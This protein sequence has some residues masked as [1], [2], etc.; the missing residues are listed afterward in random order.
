MHVKNVSWNEKGHQARTGN[1]NVVRAKYLAT[2]PLGSILK[3]NATSTK[4]KKYCISS[5]GSEDTMDSD[6]EDSVAYESDIQ[7]EGSFGDQCELEGIR[8]EKEKATVE[9]DWMNRIGIQVGSMVDGSS[10]MD[11]ISMHLLPVHRGSVGGPKPGVPLHHIQERT[12]LQERDSFATKGKENNVHRTNP[13]LFSSTAYDLNDVIVT[14]VQEDAMDDYGNPALFHADFGEHDH[15]DHVETVDLDTFCALEKVFNK[16]QWRHEHPVGN[17][18]GSFTDKR[19][20]KKNDSDFPEVIVGLNGAVTI[21]KQMSALTAVDGSSV[22]EESIKRS[23]ETSIGRGQPMSSTLLSSTTEPTDDKDLES[24]EKD[25]SKKWKNRVW[26]LSK[27]HLNRCLPTKL[28]D[29][30]SIESSLHR[31]EDN[32]KNTPSD[33]KKSSIPKKHSFLSKMWQRNRKDAETTL[34]S[35]STTTATA[36]S[37]SSS[38][39]SMESGKPISNIENKTSSQSE[40]SR[41]SFDPPSS[42]SLSLSTSS[43]SEVSLWVTSGSSTER[44]NI[45]KR[46]DE[47]CL[48]ML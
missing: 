19:T 11:K 48:A 21:E 17:N 18:Q 47:H 36:S 42:S 28:N 20:K 2:P 44:I 7:S 25:A 4:Q 38:C 24:E 3:R 39:N 9:N 27:K 34:S 26:N 22:C 46:N 37:P 5:Y 29:Y 12:P 33:A 30:E 43:S 13:S 8:N 32:E 10:H 31:W 40:V 23:L 15:I 1:T 45:I 35:S 16:S 41:L 14:V 6:I